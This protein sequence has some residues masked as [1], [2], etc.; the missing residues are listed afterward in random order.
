MDTF[1]TL[2]NPAFLGATKQYSI[3]GGISKTRNVRALSIIPRFY[4]IE[5]TLQFTLFV[6]KNI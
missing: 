5:K 1:I 3:T 6:Y 4:K 2:G